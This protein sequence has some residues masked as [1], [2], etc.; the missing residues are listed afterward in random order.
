[1]YMPNNQAKRYYDE[2]VVREPADPNVPDSTRKEYLSSVE[3]GSTYA[4]LQ[5][6]STVTTFLCIGSVYLSYKYELLSLIQRKLVK[7][8]GK[9]D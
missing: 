3:A 7:N 6:L 9:I 4:F 2:N 1:M 5:I 8:T